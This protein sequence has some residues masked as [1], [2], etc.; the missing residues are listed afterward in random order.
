M[1][2]DS[3]FQ[4]QDPSPWVIRFAACIPPA[5]RVL[6]LAC[7][8]GRHAR[9]LAG[10]GFEVVAADRDAS[11]LAR[12]AD[13][14]L[15]GTLCVDLEEGTWP[16]INADF[17]A[18]VVTRYLFRPRLDRLAALLRPGGV[19]IYETFMAGNERFGKPSNPDFLLRPHELLD[20]A[21]TWG[22]VVAFE[23]GEIARPAPAM[24][25]RICAVRSDASSALP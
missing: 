4:V 6:D 2:S 14:P 7:G 5:A 8:T 3:H 20:W 23:Q 12:L 1:P 11:A 21:R 19:L 15:A 25:Q 22:Q 16:W 24:I 18:V 10:R 17:D 13:V 9:W